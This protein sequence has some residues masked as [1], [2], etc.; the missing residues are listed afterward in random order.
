MRSIWDVTQKAYAG[1]RL[2]F[3]DALIL[4]QSTNL[5]L[6]AHLAQQVR[7]QKHPERVVTFI[8]S[9]NINYTNACWV[10]CKFCAFY[11]LPRSP[12]AYTLTNEE[13]LGKVEEL[14]AVGGYDILIQGGLNPKLRI[15]YFERLFGDIKRH[16]PHV[17]I[18]GL[19]V[20]E[21]LYMAKIS[22]LSVEEALT[23]LQRA[24]M[25]TIPGA[26]GEILV[27]EVR[28]A[29]APYKDRTDEWLGLMRTAH[30]LGMR[31]TA[32]M[33]YG[34]VETVAHRIEHLVR[35]RELQDETGGFTAFA[36]WNFQP[37]K[38]QLHVARK[39]SGLDHL[40]M[41]A[42]SRLMLDNVDNLQASWVTQG[43][44]IAQVSLDYGVNDFGQTMMEENVVSAAGT[45]FFLSVQDIC[46]LI[47]N[48]GYRPQLRNTYYDI[49]GDPDDILPHKPAAAPTHHDDRAD[50]GVRWILTEDVYRR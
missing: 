35:I 49:L 47:R 5:P 38:T 50:S 16:F 20:S 18:H 48:A 36:A 17:H 43:P 14:V 15:D 4:Y 22:K 34:H 26:G 8:V 3:D 27:D 29:I 24:G 7:F 23:R 12:E 28:E 33:M 42:V 9:R 30:R 41:M 31:S 40:K 11:R 19:S 37:E 25:A 10:Q 21:I 6:L 45:K 1:E 32:T 46:R 39:A 44:K 13:V 2:T